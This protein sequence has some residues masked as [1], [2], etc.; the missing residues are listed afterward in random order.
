M[1]QDVVDRFGSQIVQADGQL[2]R[3]ALRDLIFKDPSAKDDLEALLLPR[4][5]RRYLEWLSEVN[6]DLISE[7][8]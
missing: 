5:R 4:I 2:D 6:R 3:S 7:N 8:F 1:F